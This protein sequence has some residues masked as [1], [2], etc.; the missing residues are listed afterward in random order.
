MNLNPSFFYENLK[1]SCTIEFMKIKSVKIKL[2]IATLSLV[3]LSNIVVG[4]FPCWISDTA[5]EKSAKETM[6]IVAKNISIQIDETNQKEFR[7][8]GTLAQLDSIRNSDIF[9]KDKVKMISKSATAL[10]KNYIIVSAFDAFGYTYDQDWKR[11]DIEET[12]TY[13]KTMIGKKWITDPEELYGNLAMIYSVPI[14]DEDLQPSG[15]VYA[16]IK[17]DRMSAVCSS[18]TI[19]KNSHPKIVNRKTGVM[20]GSED[21][22]DIRKKI[23]IKN[24]LNENATDDYSNILKSICKGESSWGTYKN[25]DG[26]KMAVAYQPIGSSCDWSVICEA[27]YNDYFG[28]L[29]KMSIALVISIASAIIVAIIV[30]VLILSKAL[31]PLGLVKK[32]I[33]EI[34]TG[35][36]DLTKRIPKATEDEIGD[37]VNGFNLFSEKLQQII[38]DIKNSKEILGSTGENLKAQ[39]SDT[40]DS[41]NG[42]LEN[43]KDISSDFTKH[44]ND[45]Q[46]T[47]EAVQGITEKINSQKQN[48]EEQS[49]DISSAS[50]AIESMMNNIISVNNSMDKMSAAFAKLIKSA[51]EGT[52]QQN[53]V[54]E[55]IK[56]IEEESKLLT[57]AN[58]TIALIAS[59]TNLLA[60]NA[61]IEAAHA[62]DAGKGFSV[63]ADEIRALSETSSKQSKTI[64]HQLKEIDAS[65]KSMVAASELSKE[66]FEIVASQ[67]RDTNSAV[68][69]IKTSLEEQSNGSKKIEKSL[70][71]MNEKT[72]SVK[73]TSELMTNSS[74]EIQKII[75]NLKEETNE[76]L[77]KM[78]KMNDGAESIKSTSYILDIISDSVGQSI[79]EIGKQIERFKV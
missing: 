42:I 27:P 56:K 8:L 68:Q 67:I 53:D 61:A 39:I 55:K 19:G 70:H 28:A 59:E 58:K 45:V 63:V 23:N 62:G 16:F 35:N 22:E 37:V 21:V 77:K 31:K 10:D 3:I 44:T 64:G 79:A 30:A 7:M 51:E 12:I 66:S 1:N 17:A 34:A 6:E 69:L 14:F 47:S 78:A 74:E 38:T 57:E 9:I 11:V 5:L 25:K 15:A 43:I 13:D 60:M 40:N 46:I 26:V 50:I 20:I 49:Q 4:F 41:I 2:I 73:E 72:N 18:I 54:N 24:E 48:I 52:K 65:I 75:M 29:Q 76:F 71:T 32:S 33:N 36:A